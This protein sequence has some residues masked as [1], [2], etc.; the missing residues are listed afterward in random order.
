MGFLHHEDDIGP[1]DQFGGAGHFRVGV[2]AGGGDFE[3]RARGEDV[4]GG[5]A[6]EF[7]AAAEEEDAFHEQ[8]LEIRALLPP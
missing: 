5:R 2:Q 4:L 6:A 8:L 7:V 3:V 1:F